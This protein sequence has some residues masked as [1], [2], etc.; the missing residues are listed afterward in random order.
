LTEGI[1]YYPTGPKF[2]LTNEAA[3]IKAFQ[4]Q[5]AGLQVTDDQTPATNSIQPDAQPMENGVYVSAD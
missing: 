3:A 4:E 1:E 5:Q 2:K